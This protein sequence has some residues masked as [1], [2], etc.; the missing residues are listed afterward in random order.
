M[1]HMIM[2]P[3]DWEGAYCYLRHPKLNIAVQ[4]DG[5][6]L[7]H[8]DHA[9]EHK[10]DVTVGVSYRK[11]MVGNI[12]VHNHVLRAVLEGNLHPF[13]V[14]FWIVLHFSGIHADGNGRNLGQYRTEK[15][16]KNRRV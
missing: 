5:R 1:I 3:P 11:H 16:A 7:V 14:S 12:L 6:D 15:G 9:V 13:N 2:P 8:V 4:N 10:G